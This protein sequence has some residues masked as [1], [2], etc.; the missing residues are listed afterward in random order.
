MSV[1]TAGPKYGFM[2]YQRGGEI[3][4]ATL[5]FSPRHPFV[6]AC[7]RSFVRQFKGDKHGFQGPLLVTRVYDFAQATQPHVVGSIFVAPPEVVYPLNW[8]QIVEIFS[9]PADK[10]P[11]WKSLERYA[12]GMHLWSMFSRR[13]NI[14]SGSVLA[15]V[16]RYSCP[17]VWRWR[18]RVP[19]GAAAG[20]S[21]RG[22]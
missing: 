13:T 20:D 14:T 11:R 6:A 22:G 15:S 16:M 21:L 4:N 9:M 19:D 3:N 1:A 2:G 7:I 5:A 18:H 10:V 12:Y 8:T 17:S